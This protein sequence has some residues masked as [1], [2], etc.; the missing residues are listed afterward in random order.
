MDFYVNGLIKGRVI[1]SRG[2][3]KDCSLSPYLFLF[4]Q[5]LFHLLFRIQR[6]GGI[7]WECSDLEP[8]LEL[9]TYFLWMTQSYLLELR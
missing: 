3:R 1:P 7:L 4:V 5:T 9:T 2:L 6:L 8:F